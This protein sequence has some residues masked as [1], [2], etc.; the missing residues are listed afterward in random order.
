[1]QAWEETAAQLENAI[2]AHHNI[3]MDLER[4]FID[5]CPI[6][7]QR[8]ASKI[9]RQLESFHTLLTQRLAE[10]R[11]STSRTRNRLVSKVYCLPQEILARI[12]WF[13][14]RGV[15]SEEDAVPM[16]DAIIRIYRA[17]Y[18]MTSVCSVWR[19]AGLIHGTLWSLIPVLP[20]PSNPYFLVDNATRN[21]LD[22]AGAELHL[23][24]DLG[25]F[26]H[27][28]IREVL[29]SQG[30]RL[31]TV[32]IRASELS[33]IQ[34]AF[35][36][37]ADNSVPGFI[38]GLSIWLDCS[39]S[40]V[41]P[42]P[43]AEDFIFY[44][45]TSRQAALELIANSL[46]VLRLRTVNLYMS[47]LSFENLV[48]L[49]LQ[50]LV[51][52]HKTACH[53]LLRALA[54]ASQLCDL[55]II[56]VI[57]WTSGDGNGGGEG[58]EADQVPNQSKLPIK[59]PCL[60]RLFL[61]DLY[62]NVTGTI[63]RSIIPGPYSLVLSIT[64]KF[65]FIKKRHGTSFCGVNHLKNGAYGHNVDT[66]MMGSHFPM[67]MSETNLTPVLSAVPTATTL[68]IDG[69][70][71][72]RA[73]FWQMTRTADGN[74]GRSDLP[75]FREVHISRCRIESVED[76]SSFK[77]MISSHPIQKFT[78][79]GLLTQGDRETIGFDE[80]DERVADLTDW[81]EATVPEFVVDNLHVNVWFETD[82]WQ[83]W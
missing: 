44:E 40:F 69:Q 19:N 17:L 8:V 7:P 5:A 20:E 79:G 2:S 82:V 41:P 25:D 42:P 78:M 77:N 74:D 53:G 61:E 50:D 3:C 43:L 51:L 13:T 45:D 9:D 59:L 22:R 66:V 23:A 34:K 63:L 81:F 48:K 15:H 68:Y 24:A 67:T 31:R 32:N 52:G 73:S 55:E 16:N 58:E 18:R 21:C 10:S 29:S 26:L 46:Y 62:A 47:N 36:L 35:T 76:P 27:P 14:V 12:F 30:A 6:D 37:L 83:L 39:D 33:V 60:R 57:A 4:R 56:S 49:R 1:M 38:T 54:S 71:V 65:Q 64:D 11:S 80:P 70:Y 28:T 72:S 75:K